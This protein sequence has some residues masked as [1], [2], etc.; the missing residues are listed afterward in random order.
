M[1]I[2]MNE[3][4]QEDFLDSAKEHTLEDLKLMKM[5]HLT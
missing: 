3:E 4:E 5:H 1:S 2:E